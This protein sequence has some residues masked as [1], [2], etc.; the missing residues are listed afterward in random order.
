MK[1]RKISLLAVAASLLVSAVPA[2]AVTIELKLIDSYSKSAPFGLAFDGTNIFWSQSNGQIQ[3]MTTSGV[4]VGST[5]GGPV[6][7]ELAWDGS[8]LLSAQ[9]NTLYSFD[10]DGS[11]VTTSTIGASLTGI[12]S[13]QDGLDWDNNELWISPDIGNIFR[14]AGDLATGSTFLSGSYSGVERFQTASGTD[15]L[16]VVNDGSSPRQLCVHTLGGSLLGC[17][18]F[19]NDRYEG[20]AFDG[21]YLWA[22]DYFGGR[23]DKFD[24]LADGG[25]I[26]S[27]PV[28]IPAA[29]WLLG[30]ALGG[31]GLV[32]RR[33]A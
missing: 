18:N 16:A 3:K 12:T 27:P 15:Y 9:Y 22:A 6:W 17:Q 32:R 33:K 21:R 31:M 29:V 23:I 7:S 25:S 8:H 14:V 20:L 26:I 2:S 30:S 28:P 4:D 19:T 5:F 10:R 13:L 1:N 11:N 24:I